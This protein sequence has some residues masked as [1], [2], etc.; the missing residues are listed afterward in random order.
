[1]LVSVVLLPRVA[2]LSCA[3]RKHLRVKPFFWV[4]FPEPLVLLVCSIPTSLQ[5]LSLLLCC[6]V[7]VGPPAAAVTAAAVVAVYA[8]TVAR[9]HRHRA[10]L[11]A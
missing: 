6:V 1:M 2:K 7:R 8:F 4:F 9:R 11:L 3:Y 10:G 5:L